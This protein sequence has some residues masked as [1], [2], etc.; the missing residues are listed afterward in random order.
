MKRSPSVELAARTSAIAI[1]GTLC[2]TGCN[3]ESQGLAS[4]GSGSLTVCP[5]TNVITDPPQFQWTYHA[6]SDTNP[7]A[8]YSGTLEMGAASFLIGGQ[9]LTTRAYRQAG[10]APSIPGPTIK[11]QPGNKYVL[12][13]HNRL[14]YQPASSAM[15]VFKDPNVSNVHTHGLHISGESPS[16]DV[17]RSFEGGFGG[18]FV[19]D[20]PA[21]HMGGTYWY[22]AHHHGSTYPPGLRRRLR[23][24]AHRRRQRRHPRERRRHDRAPARDRLSRSRRGRHRRRHVDERH[25]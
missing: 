21:D 12:R 14:P 4:R 7:T 16:D 24:D 5:A 3:N 19:Y 22:H 15:N 25:A 20:I 2:L 6:P 10:T 17:S 9:T 11:M 13:F 23:P 18:D 1:L 8:Y